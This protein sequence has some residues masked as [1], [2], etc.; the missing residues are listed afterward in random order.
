MDA[1]TDKDP[2][3]QEQIR[4]SLCA[5]GDADP[6]EILECCGEYLRQHDKLPFPFR[7]LILRSMESVIRNHL[8]E[9]GKAAAG[10]VVALAAQEM[11]KSKEPIQEWQEAASDVLVEIGKRF[12]NKVMEEVLGKFQPGILP[13]PCVLRTFGNLAL[14]NVFGMVPFL[15]SI[16]G[17]LLP[18]LGMVRTDSMKCTFCY[19]LQRFSESIQEYLAGRDQAP[20]PTIRRD[21]FAPE[22][23]AAFE[24]LLQGWGQSREGQV[25]LAVLEA[26][27]PMSSLIPEEKLEEQ[28]P[29]L[30]PGIL[31]LYKKHPE[32]FPISKS[33]CQILESSVAIGSRSLEAQLESLLATLLTQICAPADPNVPTSA[34]NHT[35]LLRC[36]SVLACAF[37]ERLLPFLAPKL[38]SGSERT[39]AGALL[40][41]RHLLNSAP[42][43]MEMKKSFIISSLR[44]PLQDNNNKVKR[45]L[46][47]LISAL[48]HHGY[49]E[50]PGAEALLEFLVRQCCLQ[51]GPP[52]IP[53]ENSEDPTNEN[54]RSISVSTLLLLSTTVPRMG[55]VLWPFLLEFLIPAQFS[56]ALTPLCRSLTFLAGKIRE[57][58][59]ENEAVSSQ[60]FLGSGRGAAALR[61]LGALRIHPHLENRWEK[62]I[63]QLLEHL[64]AHSFSQ[65][66]RESLESIPD[67]SWICPLVSEMFRQLRASDGSRAEKNFLYRSMGTALGS[68]PSKELVRKQLQELLENARYQDEAEREGLAS[69]FG[70]CARDHLEETLEKLEEFV[71]SDVF[72]KSLGLFSIFKERSE[73][74]LE[75]LRSGLVLC[76]GRV[77]EAAPPELL[78]S[79]L[80]SQILK[81]LLQHGHTKVR[82]RDFLGIW[83]NFWGILKEFLGNFLGNVWNFFRNFAGIFWEFSRNFPRIFQDFLENFPGEFLR[84]EPP[85]ALRTRLRQQ[86]L[87][88]CKFQILPLEFQDFPYRIPGYF[89][90]EFQD[91]PARIPGF[92]PHSQHLGSWI[93][94]PREQERERA[95]GIS[96]SLLEFFL[97][98]LHV[99]SI[100]PFY[101]LSSLLALLAPR[102]SDGIPKIRADSVDCVRS[103][104]RIQLCYEGFSRDHQDEL[105]EGLELLKEGLENPDF[106]IL[107]HT[108]TRMG[109]VIGKRIPPEQLLQLLLELFQAWDDPDGNC[110]RAASVLCNSLLRERG[111]ILQEKV[112]DLLAVIRS[113]LELQ[114]PEQLRRAAQQ[115]VLILGLQHPKA[116]LGTLL[117]SALPFDSSAMWRA[118]GTEPAL[119]SQILE[120]LLE[121]LSREVPFTESKPFLLGGAATRVATAPPLA[122]TCALDELMSVPEAA[123]AVLERFPALF[124][125]LLLRLGCSVGVQLP[126]FLRNSCRET[127]GQGAAAKALRPCSCAVETLQAML[128]RA[129]NDDV[130]RDVGNSGG[131]ELMEIPERHHD[132]IA[133]LAGAMARLCGPRLP[134]IVRSLIP[135]LGSVFEC[136]RVTSTAFLAE[137]LNHKV[138]N[139]LLLLEPLLDALTALEK[140]SCLLVRVLALRGLGNVASGSPEQIR[141]HGAQLL[142]SMVHGMDD[143][144]DPNNRL[145]LE[146]MSSLSKILDHLEQRDVH[147]T[148]LRVA[149]RIRPFFDSEHPELRHS[150]IVLFGNL[151]RFGRSDSEVFSEQVLNGL[152][153][154]LLHLQDP[155]PDVVK[156]CKFA[157]RM[158]G[159]SLGC[160]ELREMFGNH[161]REERGL[162]YGEFLNDVC[163]FLMRAHPALLSRLLSTN[164]FYFKSPWRELRAAAAMFIG[165]LV[166]HMDEEQG[167]Q[168]DL[169]ELISGGGKFPKFPN[170]QNSQIYKSP[171]SPIPQISKFPD[172]PN[173]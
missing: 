111:G 63:P 41:L 47:Q 82:F 97:E 96:K 58:E 17:T 104:L 3:V 65:F 48:A 69:C 139:D 164:L 152:V 91:F 62:E 51:D 7:A 77:A 49:L 23:G 126:K 67:K 60:P 32:P 95:L 73:G 99:S 103:L 151:S 11:T 140:D 12:L 85:D 136:Q 22:M 74:E 107:F 87:S 109:S 86:A 134:P 133:L 75:K 9:L 130:V 54:V 145:A 125:R 53:E 137:L 10:A 167:Q 150:S 39:R 35:E 4:N 13:H 33:L 30:L 61:L 93:K 45:A 155:Q 81:N 14:A 141:R 128:V 55:P 46:V 123:A 112:P 100:T 173:P 6:E 38:E 24:I 146:A 8:P 127:R 142:A 5:L 159:P 59:P 114:E 64:E 57:E 135:E 50:Q 172:S 158:C 70:I 83:G 118:L 108:C 71:K 25:R 40:V 28:I 15:N 149:I 1:T 165:F 154:L 161:L 102:C 36:F 20:D 88:T 117:G 76:Y 79:R 31:S 44:L 42:S 157:L 94:S 147:S 110:S 168:V 120:L 56:P 153:T 92:F 101:N 121:R 132:G 98:N 124:Q 34:K 68:C 21:A 148:L 78:H 72:K 144:D 116:V 37:P 43:Q 90:P 27:G 80:E 162:H 119:S 143:Q 131:W 18:M 29:K 52:G 138:V 89:P 169:D 2:E 66:L 106:S 163:K 105:L 129:G 113:K 84:A 26:L 156:A 171:K 160:E 19:A 115:S 170:P 122:A 166:L 16:L